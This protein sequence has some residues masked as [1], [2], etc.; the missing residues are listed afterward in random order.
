[1]VLSGRQNLKLIDSFKSLSTA[2][3]QN[4]Q[5]CL[6]WQ[7]NWLEEPLK[8][9]YLELFSYDK[10]KAISVRKLYAQDP[11]QGTSAYLC[12]QYKYILQYFPLTNQND[13]WSQSWGG[14]FSAPNVYISLIG[15]RQV[16]QGF[17][18]LWT[19]FYQ[20]KHNVFFWLLMKDR[21]ST[22]NI[23]RR[24]NIQLES[25]NCVLCQ[26]QSE[27]TVQHLFLSCPFAKECW[28]VLNIDFQVDS[29]FPKALLQIRVQ[30]HSHFFHVG[31]YLNELGNL[32]SKK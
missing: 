28:S 29:A 27:E 15:H 31:G 10:L 4:G 20:P 16:H 7:D 32:D 14:K 25:Y 19:Y 30:S 26:S 6:F 17:K 23:L 18:W 5:S 8:D 2:Q 21:L 13:I 12:W 1:M 9:E 11:S 22:R 24:K 3:V